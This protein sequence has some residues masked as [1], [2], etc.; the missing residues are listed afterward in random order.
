MPV[1]IKDIVETI[2]MPTEMGSPLYQGWQSGR[3]A[4]TCR[5]C[6]TRRRRY[7]ARR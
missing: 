5:R 3:D 4:A 7:S 2:D 1:G 6:A